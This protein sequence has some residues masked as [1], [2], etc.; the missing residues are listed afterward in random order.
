MAKYSTELT[1]KICSLIRADSYTIAEICEIVGIAES[2]FYKWKDSVMEFSEAIKKAQEESKG[3]F[4]TE[5][6]KSLLKLVQGYTIEEKRT[7]TVDS[8]KKSEDGKPIVKVKEHTTVSKYVAPN[9]TAIIFTLTNCDPM[10]WKNR[11][12]AE[13]TGKDGKPL[14]PPDM[15][16]NTE[17]FSPTDIAKL[18]CKNGK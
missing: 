16:K 15:R 9:P 2:T 7:V 18:L 4:A 17:A 14:I 8:G 11:Q 6:K 3:F 12:S 5:A 10:N 13:F 1:E